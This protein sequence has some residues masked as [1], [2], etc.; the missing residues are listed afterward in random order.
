MPLPYHKP[1]FFVSK[2]RLLIPEPIFYITQYH[3][4]VVTVSY[5]PEDISK[6]GGRYVDFSIDCFCLK[7]LQKVYIKSYLDSFFKNIGVSKFKI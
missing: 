1:D 6:R 3:I 4:Y 5:H 2:P 7:G